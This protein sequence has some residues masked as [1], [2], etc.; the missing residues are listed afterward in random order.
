MAEKVLSEPVELGMNLPDAGEVAGEV[1][2]HPLAAV[3]S[4]TAEI[5]KFHV[6]RHRV[7]ESHQLKWPAV[8]NIASGG[9]WT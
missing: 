9:I 2:E 4:P 7:S 1:S 3:N 5:E 8:L 6:K